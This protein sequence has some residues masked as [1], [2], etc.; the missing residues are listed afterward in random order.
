MIMLHY[1]F[2]DHCFSLIVLVEHMSAV[3][4]TY[5]VFSSVGLLFLVLLYYLDVCIV[6]DQLALLHLI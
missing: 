1:D 3:K 5:G 6:S 2:D 4:T